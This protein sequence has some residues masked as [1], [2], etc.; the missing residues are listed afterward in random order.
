M[1]RLSASFLPPISLDRA[2]GHPVY[3]QLYDWF[4][5]AIASGQLRPGQRVPST[6]ALAAELNLSRIPVLTAFEQLL[7]EGYLETFHGAGTCVASS[8]PQETIG[9]APGQ[10]LRKIG[11][12][13]QRKGTR[14]ISPGSRAVKS[15]AGQAWLK[16]SGAFRMHLPALDHFPMEIWSRLVARNIRKGEKSLMAYGDAMGYAP[17]REAIAEYLGAVRAVRCDPSQ[18]MVTTGSQQGLQISASVLL[19]P[20]APVWMEEPGYPGAHQAF[21]TVGVR[22]IPVPVD[23]E[24]LNV[25]EGIRRCPKA[26][27]VYITPSHQYPMGMTMSATRRMQLLNW[28]SRAGAWIIEDDYD[29]E[30]R[31]GI[32]P[33]GSLQGLDSDARVIY[34]GT[35]SKV[36]FPALRLGYLVIPEDLVRMFSVIREATDIFSS[37]L[38]QAVMTDFI[39]EGHFARHVRRMRGLYTERCRALEESLRAEMGRLMEVVSADAGMHLV[40]LLP[41]HFHDVAVSQ[42]AAQSGISAMPLSNCYLKRPSRPGL[43]L[44]YGPTDRA[45]IQDGVRTLS[46]VLRSAPES[47]APESAR[48]IHNHFSD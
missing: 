3:R 40:G 34:I 35:F 7:A 33:I 42:K 47:T 39:K 26:R 4:Q 37:M 10:S 36:M 17:F 44:G 28:A 15:L 20:G 32:R 16:L 14:K 43:V 11:Q 12:A 8:I 41:P 31:F 5:R 24:G 18:V 13:S 27:A 30:Y 29:S 23:G 48:H 25:A 19:G 22:L 9:P 1:K 21:A 6:R 46:K 2:K 45:Q 38:Y